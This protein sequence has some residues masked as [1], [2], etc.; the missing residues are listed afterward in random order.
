MSR[1]ADFGRVAIVGSVLLLAARTSPAPAAMMYTYEIDSLVHLSSDIVEADLTRRYKTHDSELI[2]VKLTRVHKGGLKPGA[3]VTV[4]GTTFYGKPLRDQFGVEPLAAGDRL[5]FFLTRFR[6][7]GRDA[8]P[9]DPVI[10]APVPSGMKLVDNDRVFGFA[11]QNNPGPYVAGPENPGLGLDAPP[12]ARFRDRLGDSLR[13][14]P[15]LARLVE[16]EPDRLDVSKLLELLRVRARPHW[17]GRDHFRERACG[18]LAELREPEWLSRALPLAPGYH[19]R[20]ILEYGFGSPK[21]RAYLLALVRD[22]REPIVSRLTHAAALHSAGADDPG[23]VVR[24]ARAARAT[25]RHEA[26]CVS[27]IDGVRSVARWYGAPGHD[28]ATAEYR[29]A[30][31]EL[32]DLYLGQ[33]AEGIQFAIERAT[34][35]EHAAYERLGAP[36]GP[37]VSILRPVPREQ[38]P[39]PTP[40]SLALLYE[41]HATPAAKGMEARPEVVLVNVRTQRRHVFPTP[42]RL[43]GGMGGSG[44]FGIALPDDVPAGRY[45]VFLQITDGGRVVSTGHWFVAD[46]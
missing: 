24:L 1:R 32:R 15:V 35:V 33:P 14:V 30:L 20:T 36:C 21:G 12:V 29:A 39:R 2:E 31:A 19:E 26:L 41:Y 17:H 45:R 4:A 28:A 38:N 18:R 8:L 44:T 37:F 6:P 22:E 5:V 16:A 25:E 27:L 9:A 40:R 10:Y 3:T 46:V 11:Q 13:E 7:G 42:I 43:K 34:A 23:H